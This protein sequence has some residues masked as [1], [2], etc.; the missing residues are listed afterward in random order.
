M[1]INQ[2][3]GSRNIF[4]RTVRPTYIVVHYTGAGTSGS[5][6]ALANCK[7][8]AR[9]YRAASAHYFV[10]DGGVWEYADP[11]SYGTWHCGDGH[12]R[13]GVTNTN[14]IG[15]EVC[16]SGDKPYTETEIGY[17]TEL[18]RKL[19]SDFSIPADHVVR[20]YDASRKACP[21]YY[22][23]KGSGGDSAWHALRSRITG[24]SSSGGSAPATSGGSTAPSG[25]VSDIARDVIAGKYGNGE[26]RK[27]ALG[28]RYVEV[29][30]EVNRI[31][32]GGSKSSGTSVD[33]DALARDVIAGKYGNG[34]ARKRAL[35]SNYAAVQARV[36][37]IL[38]SGKSSVSAKAGKSIDQLAREVIRGD[39]G[40]G[41][42][43]K[44]RLTAAGYD[45][46]AVQKRVNQLL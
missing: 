11:W 40:N 6:A 25:S 36:N 39:W 8:F 5:G 9:A 37:E 45:Y 15:V 14:S 38:G 34:D 27:A 30:A 42:E 17:L 33:I 24:G 35:G 16:Q 32:S 29:Q 18:V 20:H 10:D 26:A 2:H 23:P 4:R 1:Q 13:Y 28:S 22:T 43:R 41:A 46:S 3:H 12:G 7:Y 19:M 21:L 44:R 31:L